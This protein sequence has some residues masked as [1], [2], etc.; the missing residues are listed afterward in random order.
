M[1]IRKG[2]LRPIDF[3]GLKILDF[4]GGKK[5]SSS[6][7]EITVSPG[8]RH[9]EAWSRLSDKYYYV[10]SGKLSFVLDGQE[11]ELDSGDCSVV[12]Q[13]QHFSY[14]NTTGKT[15]KILLVHT[16]SFNMES[17]VFVE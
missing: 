16:P 9:P 6:V 2:S 12:L 8:A 11:H 7:A 17:E 14:R 13:G 4:T 1:I 15:A 10:V 3:S 5:T